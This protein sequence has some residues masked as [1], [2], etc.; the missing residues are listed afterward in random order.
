MD[1]NKEKLSLLQK[2]PREILMVC[3]FAYGITLGS[4]VVHLYNKITT[5]YADQ[6]TQ[7]INALNNSTNAVNNSTEAITNSTATLTEIQKHFIAD[8]LRKN[9]S[10][11]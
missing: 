4:V 10:T 6:N 9:K 7:L 1:I 5:M 3:L 2:Y 8:G 11:E